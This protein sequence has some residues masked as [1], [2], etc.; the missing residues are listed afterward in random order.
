MN[1]EGSNQVGKA[2]NDWGLMC[3]F[4][5]GADFQDYVNFLCTLP[6]VDANTVQDSTGATCEQRAGARASDLNMPSITVANL[7][8]KRVVKRTLR[9]V[10]GADQ[11]ESYTVAVSAPTG[12]DVRVWPDWFQLRGGES[13]VVT[14]TLHATQTTGTFTF[15]SLVWHGSHGH[16]VRIPVSVLVGEVI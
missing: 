6:G 9:S 15:G 14:V 8:G 4:R 11:A 12:V 13:V 1:E 16:V 7:V 3:S 2:S 10:A 5:D